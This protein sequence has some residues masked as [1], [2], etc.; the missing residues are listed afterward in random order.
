[1]AMLATAYALE[2]AQ[3]EWYFIF[4][5]PASWART[6]LF[7]EQNYIWQDQYSFRQT[8]QYQSLDV[9]EIQPISSIH[10]DFLEQYILPK[11]DFDKQHF[12]T[13]KFQILEKDQHQKTNNTH[14]RWD[15]DTS[16]RI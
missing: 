9:G 4:T 14:T 15:R 8:S 6:P 5:Y 10:L 1:M 2:K 3:V 11:L 13:I 16:K 12:L 7:P